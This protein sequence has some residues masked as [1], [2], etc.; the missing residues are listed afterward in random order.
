MNLHCMTLKELFKLTVQYK[1]TVKSIDAKLTNV[2]SAENFLY[3]VFHPN[4]LTR[5]AK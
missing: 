4:I 3:S 1:N 2:I 5:E